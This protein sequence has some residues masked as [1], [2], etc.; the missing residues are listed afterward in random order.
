MADCELGEATAP[1]AELA[2]GLDDFTLES[3]VPVKPDGHG[4]YPVA[5]PGRTRVL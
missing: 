5:M 3:E 1:N 4:N 2:L